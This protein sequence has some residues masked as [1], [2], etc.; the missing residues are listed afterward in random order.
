MIILGNN[1]FGNLLK[2]TLKRLKRDFYLSIGLC[3]LLQFIKDGATQ[4]VENRRRAIFILKRRFEGGGRE[5]VAS[6]VS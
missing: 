3:L 6:R 5:G 1:I 2:G 4:V